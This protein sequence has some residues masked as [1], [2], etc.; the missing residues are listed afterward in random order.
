MNANETSD[1][2]PVTER[3][4]PFDNGGSKA[5]QAHAETSCVSQLIRC[6]KSQASAVLWSKLE[7]MEN[8]QGNGQGNG[9]HIGRQMRWAQLLPCP[10]V[11]NF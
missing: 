7:N 4:T 5:K 11:V 6:A 8:G 3:V 9:R 1:E 10:A 2:E